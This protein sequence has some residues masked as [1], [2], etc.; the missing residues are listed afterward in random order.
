[1]SD[2]QPL[3]PA[4][5][6]AY[7]LLVGPSAPTLRPAHDLDAS[8]AKAHSLKWCSKPLITHHD[9][10]GFSVRIR[11]PAATA[12]LGANCNIELLPA[13]AGSPVN[14][15]GLNRLYAS[16]LKPPGSPLRH[17]AGF[18]QLPCQTPA[19]AGGEDAAVATNH[20]L[21]I[22][23]NNPAGF[24]RAC[25]LAFRPPD[26]AINAQTREGPADRHHENE[27]S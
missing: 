10:P 27:A 15:L 7:I 16:A 8:A 11:R 14:R 12:L 3:K 24:S 18:S 4:D 21:S 5:G 23:H 6:T 20:D 9:P 17:P 22:H 2:S 1:M 25:A 13:S 19:L 26:A